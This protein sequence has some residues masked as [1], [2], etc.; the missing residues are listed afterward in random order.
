MRRF[1]RSRD[2]APQSEWVLYLL[3]SDGPA[4]MTDARIKEAMDHTVTP[5]GWRRGNRIADTH[6]TVSI[7][8]Q[9]DD[10]MTVEQLYSF[11]IKAKRASEVREQPLVADTIADMYRIK[12]AGDEMIYVVT[13][14]GRAIRAY[15]QRPKANAFMR[16]HGHAYAELKIESI[17]LE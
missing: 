12:I 8:R 13:Q 4:N 6:V 10:S 14:H 3:R 15:R 2:N 1:G 11:G 17:L 5:S 16:E 7:K 9:W